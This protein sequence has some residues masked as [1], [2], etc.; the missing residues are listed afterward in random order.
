MTF[1]CDPLRLSTLH[2]EK[3]SE[4]VGVGLELAQ[5]YKE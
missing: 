1:V 5:E 3:L 4:S 2:E